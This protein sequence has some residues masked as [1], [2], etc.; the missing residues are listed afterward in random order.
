MEKDACV[1]EAIQHLCTGGMVLGYGHKQRPESIYGN[2]GLYPGM[3]PW[4]FPYG[5][6]GFQNEAMTKW[7]SR[8]EHAHHLLMYHDRHFQRDEYFIFLVFSQ[9]QI[10]DSNSGGYILSERKHFDSISQKICNL[11]IRLL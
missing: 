3:F 5:K 10:V 11:D 1:R 9:K 6:G 2:P 4:F 7:M 8:Q